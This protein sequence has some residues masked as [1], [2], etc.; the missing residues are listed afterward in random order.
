MTE[1]R[2]SPMSFLAVIF[3]QNVRRHVHKIN[4]NNRMRVNVR[5]GEKEL[6]E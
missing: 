1:G 3:T 4:I 6:K 2:H 5:L